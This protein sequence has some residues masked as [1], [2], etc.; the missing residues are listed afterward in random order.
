MDEPNLLLVD[1]LTV[2]DTW[3]P[4]AE[5]FLTSH[6]RE[7]NGHQVRR[8]VSVRRALTAPIGSVWIELD[9]SIERP[10]TARESPD[11]AVNVALLSRNIVFEGGA[12]KTE[13]HGGHFWITSTPHVAQ[14]VMGVDIRNFGQQGTLGRYPVH[15]HYCGDVSGSVV[16][17]NTIRESNQRCIVVHATDNLLV[18]GNVALSNAAHCFMLE[19]G[20]ERGNQWI[21]NLGAATRSPIK[22]VP[23]G[24]DKEP[25]IFWISNPSNTYVGNIAAGSEGSGIWMELGVRGQHEYPGNPKRETLLLFKDNAAHSCFRVSMLWSVCSNIGSVSLTFFMPLN[26]TERGHDLSHRISSRQGFHHTRFEGLP[27]C[28]HGSLSPQNK[29]DQHFAKHFRRQRWSLHRHRPS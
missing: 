19:D 10:T 22:V 28:W 5:I 9:A 12:D 15:F 27:E 18:E 3:A 4:G 7:W 16:T 25:S 8:I 13:S 1:D 20:I 14:T 24:S 2:L 21:R 17:K 29:K 23:G 26:A 11:F 6:T